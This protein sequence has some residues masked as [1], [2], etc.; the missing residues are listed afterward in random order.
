MER[1]ILFPRSKPSEAQEPKKVIQLL[2]LH[3]DALITTLHE[4][5][6]L[7][8]SAHLLATI[9]LPTLWPASVQ[10]ATIHPAAPQPAGIY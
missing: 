9:R 1:S 3:F 5:S 6:L 4:A 2:P 8:A 10:P 7:V